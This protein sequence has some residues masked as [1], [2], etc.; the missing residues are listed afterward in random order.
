[1]HGVSINKCQQTKPMDKF[2]NKYRIPSARLQSWDYG[3]RGLYFITICTKDRN[4]YFGEIEND[5][6]V[7]NELGLIVN[8]EWEKTTE[9][10]PD[11]NLELGEFITNA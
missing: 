8:S 4:H 11:M 7:L 6:M 1:M 2:K 3:S 5:E 10:R 9:I